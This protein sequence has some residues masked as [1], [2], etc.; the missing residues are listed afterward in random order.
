MIRNKIMQG[1]TEW[2]DAIYIDVKYDIE[3]VEI[4]S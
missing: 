1:Y 4:T 2:Q 3:L